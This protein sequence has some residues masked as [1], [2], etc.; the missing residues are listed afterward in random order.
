MSHS[1][2][3][4]NLKIVAHVHFLDRQAILTAPS[5]KF[6][7]TE[8]ITSYIR[9]TISKSC[10]IEISHNISL[11]NSIFSLKWLLI[12]HGLRI[13]CEEMRLISASL[14]KWTYANTR[15]VAK[16]FSHTVPHSEFF[17]NIMSGDIFFTELGACTSIALIFMRYHFFLSLT[18]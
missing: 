2:R 3:Y 1:Y 4:Q 6:A 13:F 9:S 14:G 11:S 10:W 15:T 5:E 18:F 16:M 17:G 12:W 7:K 8:C